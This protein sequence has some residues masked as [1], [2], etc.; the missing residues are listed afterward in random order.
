MYA[1]VDCRSMATV[2]FRSETYMNVARH[3]IALAFASIGAG[4]GS[5]VHVQHGSWIGMLLGDTLGNV[6]AR[7]LD[8]AARRL[9]LHGFDDESLG[10]ED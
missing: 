1:Y 10:R 4:V 8:G 5:C 9:A 6:L 2:A 7:R 3:V